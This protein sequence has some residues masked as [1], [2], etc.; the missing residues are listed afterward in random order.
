MAQLV[1]PQFATL[2]GVHSSLLE[3]L[4]FCLLKATGTGVLPSE[5]LTRNFLVTIFGTW[6]I[7]HLMS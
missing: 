6:S 3:A 7:F 5:L 1:G 2:M 4:S